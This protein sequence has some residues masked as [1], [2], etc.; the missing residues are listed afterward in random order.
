[1]LISR[2]VGVTAA[3]GLWLAMIAGCATGQREVGARTAAADFLAAMVDGDTSAACALLA[4]TTRED[5]ETSDGQPCSSALEAVDIAGG[6]VD[7]VA[8]WGDRAQARTS[9]GTLFLVEQASGWRVAAAGC[10]RADDSTYDC[11]LAA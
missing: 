8:V 7:G 11:R 3:A 6:E 5:L 2:L 4:T 1:V 9:T 10:T